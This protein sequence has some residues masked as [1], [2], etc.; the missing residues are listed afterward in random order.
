MK[1]L[2]R[3][4][5]CMLMFIGIAACDDSAQKVKMD[6][7]DLMTLGAMLTGGE[8]NIAELK[9]LSG[10]TWSYVEYPDKI[11]RTEEVNLGA[12]DET[13]TIT[14]IPMTQKTYSM[15]FESD[16][17]FRASIR[18]V[19]TA[20]QDMQHRT[21]GSVSFNTQSYVATGGNFAAYSGYTNQPALGCSIV[22]VTGQWRRVKDFFDYGGDDDPVFQKT[23]EIRI[24][25]YTYT[26]VTDFTTD[27]TAPVNPSI[28]GAG[29]LSDS[30]SVSARDVGAVDINDEYA[31]WQEIEIDYMGDNEPAGLNKALQF[32][33]PSDLNTLPLSNSASVIV[34]GILFNS[35]DD[36]PWV[37]Q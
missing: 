27:G 1:K 13:T 16:G 29:E 15:T 21:S 37:L 9:S 30:Y 7:G 32:N 11:T 10:T 4:S 2:L 22:D 36:Q 25:G 19:F 8:D 12:I 34:G 6:S 23:Y 5:L 20:N 18:H 24:T 31:D 26:K 33:L 28:Y 3:L 14:E 35:A 17:T